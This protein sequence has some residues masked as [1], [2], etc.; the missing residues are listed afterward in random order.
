MLK[1]S[2]AIVCFL[3]ALLLES[4]AYAQTPSRG[5]FIDANYVNTQPDQG[6]Q[7][8]F[9]AV[10][11][12]ATGF[13]TIDTFYPDMPRGHGFEMGGGY[14][15][16]AGVGAGVRWLRTR[17]DY[18]IDTRI[19]VRD[20]VSFGLI[21][22]D[23]AESD[24]VH[25]TETAV[26]LMATYTLPIPRPGVQ[27][28]VFGGPTYFNVKQAMV[29]N[30]HFTSIF[31][32]PQLPGVVSAVSIDTIVHGATTSVEMSRT[33]SVGMWVWEE[34]FDTAKGRRLRPSRFL[35]RIQSLSMKRRNWT[36]GISPLPWACG[37]GSN[38]PPERSRFDSMNQ[39]Q[40]LKE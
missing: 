5:W 16:G 33:S 32:L 36:P 35:S 31:G 18:S 3:G 34:A 9:T 14:T 2:T 13:M 7:H 29:S 17:F 15:F 28:R 10:M 38:M 4:S 22:F 40:T 20:P 1:H 19:D 21:V 37:S 39:T 24:E 11:F 8:Y 12:S 30:V 26:D 23:S 6:Q 25:R 27:V